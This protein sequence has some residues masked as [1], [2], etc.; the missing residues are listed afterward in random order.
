MRKSS[1]RYLLVAA[2]LTAAVFASHSNAYL[3]SFEA[4]SAPLIHRVKRNS[5]QASSISQAVKNLKPGQLPQAS[6]SAG[7]Q[8]RSSVARQQALHND[9]NDVQTL[10]SKTESRFMAK[11]LFESG[12]YG[13]SANSFELF[14]KKPEYLKR[15]IFELHRKAPGTGVLFSFSVPKDIING[16]KQMNKKSLTFIDVDIDALNAEFENWLNHGGTK[17]ASTNFETTKKYRVTHVTYE[18]KEIGK[19]AVEV[20]VNME[21]REVRLSLGTNAEGNIN[22]FAGLVAPEQ[23]AIHNEEKGV[24]TLTQPELREVLKRTDALWKALGVQAKTFPKENVLDDQSQRFKDLTVEFDKTIDDIIHGR[25]TGNSQVNPKAV[26]RPAGRRR[27][28]AGACAIFVGDDDKVERIL[29]EEFVEAYKDAG[30][31]E[32]RK[33][34]ELAKENMDKIVDED[35]TLSAKNRKEIS[36]LIQLENTKSHVTSMDTV[37]NIHDMKTGSSHNDFSEA[38][39]NLHDKLLTVKSRVK[40]SS[41]KLSKKIAHYANTEAA[42]HFGRGIASMSDS[43]G[44]FFLAKTIITGIIHGD[45][46]TLAIVGGRIGYDVATEAGVYAGTKFFSGASKVGKFAKG[47]GKVAGPIGAVA[48]LGLGIWSLTKSVGRLK[49]ATNKFDRD[50]AIADVVTDSIDLAVTATMLTVSVIFPPA[51][52]VA[53]VVGLVITLVNQMANALFKASNEVA[54][55]NS[56][57]P[58]L[59]SE[60]EY[61]FT[62]RL[63]D[64]FGTRGQDY[65]D[66]LVE[67]KGAN[68]IAV[69]HNLQILKDNPSIYGI[70]FPSLT[71]SYD[72]GCELFKQYCSYNWGEI[73]WNWETKERWGSGCDWNKPC[74]Y[75]L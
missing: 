47:L 39:E 65:L 38:I 51:A 22:H 68:D 53:M 46:T 75:E 12:K 33:L 6:T 20:V 5:T 32:K 14:S 67:E 24:I 23:S 69:Q 4:S 58:L 44:K 25:S 15:Y 55:I 19:N 35:P 74:D 27:R 73:C 11:H 37:S 42:K 26:C 34:T 59:D 48:D 36:K 43:F 13:E 16:M 10:P 56:E 61:V 41:S 57:I 18:P 66:Y 3:A 30:E 52:P 17:G 62:S 54:R 28:A 31:E 21:Q 40:L 29:P 72:G 64:L 60:K 63:F 49:N 9:A 2:L 7:N 71:L 1:V 8:V 45:T 70:A 50:D